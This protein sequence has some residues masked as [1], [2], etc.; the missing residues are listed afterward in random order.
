[1]A[2]A[3]TDRV[4]NICL[5]PT[6]EW[7]VIAVEPTST[8]DL[9]TG[10]VAPLAAIGAAAGFIGGSLIGRSLPF[11]GTFRTPLVWGLGAA[12]FTFIMAIVGVFILGLIIDALAPTFGGEKSS[13]QALKVAVYSFTPAWVAGVLNIL[14]L[15]GLLVF[16]AACYGIYLM[17]LGL[18]VLMKSP[19]DKA[20][21]YTV[22]VVICAIVLQVVIAVVSGT[23][24][25]AGMIGSGALGSIGSSGPFGGV[26]RSGGRSSEV[27]FDKN[28]ALGKLQDLGKKLEESN[29]K[30]EAAQARG[31]SAGAAAAAVEGLG[32]L[33][34]GG[35]RV[36]PISIGDLKP[37]VPD[38]FAGLPKTSSNA[39][40][41][42]LAGFTVSKAEARYGD[43]AQKSVTLEISDTG[44]VSGLLGLAGWIGIQGEKEDDYGSERTEK[45]GGR[46]VH[47]KIS[48]RGGSNEFGLVLGDRFIVSAT[49]SGV[50]ADQLKAAVAGLDLARLESMKDVGVQK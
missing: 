31:D 45:V 19:P 46:L 50:S 37:F 48:K 24:I 12:V 28:S 1:M 15:L 49:G 36:E 44:G 22:V 32:T 38:S 20:V 9:I 18:P 30:Q 35:R 43:G 23:I 39:E 2:I 5:T 6:T 8:G 33:L 11:I 41:T 14:P 16:F 21:G 34:G 42:G 27:E 7:P 17:Y 10:Y 3:I 40:K 13:A 4:K 26:S 29:R 25:G 47:E